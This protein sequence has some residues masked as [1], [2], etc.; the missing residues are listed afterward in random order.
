MIA[1]AA[2]ARLQAG[3]IAVVS[4]CGGVDGAAMTVEKSRS[5]TGKWRNEHD[6]AM[7]RIDDAFLLDQVAVLQGRRPPILSAYAADLGHV[8]IRLPDSGTGEDALSA[9]LI[10]ASAEF[11][12]IATALRDATRDGTVCPKDRRAIVSQI[13]EAMEA[14]A[15]MRVIADG[16]R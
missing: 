10:D 9:A 2:L 7:P 8:V 5:L 4:I 15:R 13:D 12:D 16:E 11:G 14:L 6:D 3:V 1:P